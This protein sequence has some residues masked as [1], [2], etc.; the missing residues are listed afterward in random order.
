MKYFCKHILFLLV[1]LI[2]ASFFLD[3]LYTSVYCNFKPRSKFS[4]IVSLK[5]KKIDY[6]FLGSSRVANTI[7]AD[8][9]ENISKK[10]AINLGIEGADLNDNLLELKLLVSRNVKIGTLYLQVDHFF[11]SN[12]DLFVAK[13]EALPFLRDSTVSSHFKE[14]EFDYYINYYV[15]F[16]RYIEN[17]PKIGFRELLLV[18]LEKESKTNFENGFMPKFGKNNG[19]IEVLPTTISKNNN[20]LE[21]IEKICKQNNIKLVLFCAPFCSNT[22][23][24][25]YIKKLKK[26]QPNLIDYSQVINDSLF[27]DGGHLNNEGAKLFT[28]KFVLENIIKIN[29]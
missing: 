15:P 21:K 20:S 5:P 16:Y 2:L 17:S 1:T 13:A 18:F 11:E 8:L 27:F 7:D 26:I 19:K 4:Y 6:V 29:D 24:L 22:K 14:C 25:D 23:N 3:Y 10:S 12:T 28:T 9:V